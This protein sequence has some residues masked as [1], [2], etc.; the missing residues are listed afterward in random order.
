MLGFYVNELH[1]LVIFC[2]KGD[3]SSVARLHDRN[4]VTELR[5]ARITAEGRTATP[6]ERT[7]ARI[8]AT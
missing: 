8:A 1:R 4:A 2:I 3:W 7:R 6:R 5:I